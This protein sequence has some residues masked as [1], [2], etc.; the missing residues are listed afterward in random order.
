MKIIIEADPGVDGG[1]IAAYVREQI[2]ASKILPK[3]NIKVVT[4][5]A[6]QPTVTINN[7]M[8]SDVEVSIKDA[9]S[10]AVK[11]DAERRGPIYQAGKASGS[12]IAK[13]GLE[14]DADAAIISME[15][16]TKAANDAVDAAKKLQRIL[17]PRPFFT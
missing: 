15:K 8:T 1:F 9:V 13:L 11:D 16:F 14:V 10:A 6:P 7:K 2:A 17:G 12:S 4:P 5:T 3:E